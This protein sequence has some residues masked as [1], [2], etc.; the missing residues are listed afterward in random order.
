MPRLHNGS[1]NYITFSPNGLY[2]AT[3]SR[4]SYGCT[5]KLINFVSNKVCYALKNID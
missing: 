3:S 1:M 5:I 4:D 2:I